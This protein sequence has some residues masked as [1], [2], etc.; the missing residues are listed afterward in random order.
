MYIG[1]TEHSDPHRR[2]REH[3]KQYT[4][5]R[6]ENRPL[7]SAMNKYGID[8]FKFDII[9]QSENGQYL[10]EREQYYI[11]LYRTY[12]G[13]DDCNGYNLTIGGDGRPYIKL[14]ADE[15]IEYYHFCGDV[16]RKTAEH[17]NVCS[18]TIS[19]L[20]DDKGIKKSKYRFD[21][22]YYLSKYGGIVML[23]NCGF[24]VIDILSGPS[25][26]QKKY[27]FKAKQI[28]N[29][30]YKNVENPRSNGYMWYRYNELPEKYKPALEK[31]HL[32]KRLL[33]EYYEEDNLEI[34]DDLEYIYC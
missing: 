31:Y 28:T 14:D 24:N 23:D 13:Y 18:D 30:L 7:Y 4:L 22:D 21:E 6:C 27:G 34:A 9:E 1:K 15:V 32:I 5:K 8:N 10:C 3:T 19:K 16:V 33:D 25:E 17:F 26:V 20:L 11:N 29:V 2:W 12:V